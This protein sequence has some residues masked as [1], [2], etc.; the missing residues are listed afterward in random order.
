MAK[1][2]EGDMIIMDASGQY[3]G[4]AFR[5]NA[6]PPVYPIKLYIKD[7]TVFGGAAGGTVHITE[8]DSGPTILPSFA[9]AADLEQNYPINRYVDG[10]WAETISDGVKVQFNCGYY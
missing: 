2:V 9:T 6:T 1:E 5:N 4:W 10:I 3:E 8:T 7:I